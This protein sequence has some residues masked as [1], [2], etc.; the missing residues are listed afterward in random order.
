MSRKAQVVLT[1]DEKDKH[2][3]IAEYMVNGSRKQERV[4]SLAH[5]RTLLQDLQDQIDR[6]E[7]AQAEKDRAKSVSRHND[8]YRGIAV[9]HGVLFAK[10]TIGDLIKPGPQRKSPRDEADA[11]KAILTPDMIDFD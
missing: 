8:I 3:I 1:I 11:A 7:K 10:K 4:L 5:A 6:E 9:R 2:S